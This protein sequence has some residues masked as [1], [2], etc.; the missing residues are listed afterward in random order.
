[1]NLQAILREVNTKIALKRRIIKGVD[2]LGIF[3]LVA[4]ILFLYN[5]F[6]QK[7]CDYIY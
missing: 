7:H 2:L 5:R 1:M 4:M 6:Q 3:I